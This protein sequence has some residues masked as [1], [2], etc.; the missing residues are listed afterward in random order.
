M[1]FLSRNKKYSSEGIVIARKNFG[2][3]DRIITIFTKKYGKLSLL[4]KG[5]RKPKSKKRGHIEIFSHI[6]FSGEKTKGMDIVTEVET[7][8]SY[9]FLRKNLRKA[10]LAYFFMEVVNKLTREGERNEVLYK[11]L[12]EYLAKTVSSKKMR[13]I[14]NEFIYDILVL[15]GFW[16]KALLMKSPE[17]VLREVTE[18]EI[19]TI[20][21]GKRILT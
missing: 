18:R 21:V 17:S 14:K 5:V 16:P 13:A 10:S 19:S 1:S 8:N 20:R 12:L 7:I 4:A 2:E 11:F 3:A 6:K 9:S 15:L